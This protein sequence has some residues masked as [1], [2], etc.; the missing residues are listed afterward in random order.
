ME[1]Y[2]FDD[3]EMDSETTANEGISHPEATNTHTLIEVI[4]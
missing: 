2:P 1:S 3:N 4:Q